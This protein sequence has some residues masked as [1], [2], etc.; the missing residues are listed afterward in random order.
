MY[1]ALRSRGCPVRAPRVFESGDGLR[2]G[3][4]IGGVINKYGTVRTGIAMPVW[5]KQPL[6][7]LTWGADDALELPPHHILRTKPLLSICG[8]R[9]EAVDRFLGIQLKALS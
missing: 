9:K 4:L 7:R 2:F 6:L 3:A 5:P 1:T 8:S